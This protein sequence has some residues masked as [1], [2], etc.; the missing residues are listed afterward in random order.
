MKT[1]TI[2]LDQHQVTALKRSLQLEK[3]RLTRICAMERRQAEDHPDRAH[4][5]RLARTEKHLEAVKRTYKELNR[6]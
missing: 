5:D 6:R 2:T 1:K 3:A 4:K